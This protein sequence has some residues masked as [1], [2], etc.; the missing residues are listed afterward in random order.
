[1]FNDKFEAGAVGVAS[2]YGSGSTKMMRL[3]AAPARKTL[4]AGEGN[5][6]GANGFNIMVQMGLTLT[7]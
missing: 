6:T 3:L 5:G 7:D 2:R 1:M 4:I